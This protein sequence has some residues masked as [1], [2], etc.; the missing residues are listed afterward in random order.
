MDDAAATFG[1]I[2]HVGGT[3]FAVPMIE[4]EVQRAVE[5][6]TNDRPEHA[7]YA[8]IL[9]LTELATQASVPFGVH[10]NPVSEKV[11]IPIRDSRVRT[12][13]CSSLRLL[14]SSFVTLQETVR[15]KAAVLLNQCLTMV[16]QRDNQNI[17]PSSFVLILQEAQKGI[18]STSPDV[19]QG[20][21]LM[22]REL[23]KTTG[24]F[25]TDYYGDT[26]EKIFNHRTH[27]DLAVRKTVISILPTCALYNPARFTEHFLFRSMSWLLQ[28]MNKPGERTQGKHA[29]CSS[30]FKA[31]H[32]VSI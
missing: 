28:Q 27:K 3:E 9:I 2:Y 6:M 17:K 23:L 29:R 25:M 12:A 31:D 10:A 24:V 5:L 14:F 11:V 8:G 15:N 21:L 7:R 16:A 1:K 13:S 26:F 18:S 22:Y 20:S 19:I 30:E 32:T 4:N